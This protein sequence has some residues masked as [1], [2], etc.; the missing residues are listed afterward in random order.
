MKTLLLLSSIALGAPAA[1]MSDS[2]KKLDGLLQEFEGVRTRVESAEAEL[3]SLQERYADDH[4]EPELKERRERLRRDIAQAAQE[5][6]SLKNAYRS[7]QNSMRFKIVTTVAPKALKKGITEGMGKTA[8]TI[9]SYEDRFGAMNKVTDRLNLFSNKDNQVYQEIVAKAEARKT[10]RWAL[11]G[12]VFLGLAG[13]WT[14]SYI[15]RNL[16]Q[17]YRRRPGW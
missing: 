15:K 4:D 7:T 5:I 12:F 10:K 8:M 3:L 1:E 14:L 13:W 11:A 2:Y 17:T 9:M 16:R 6:E